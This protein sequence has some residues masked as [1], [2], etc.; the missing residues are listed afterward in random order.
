MPLYKF[1]N[2]NKKVGADRHRF[3]IDPVV[4]FDPT[5]SFRVDMSSLS[6]KQGRYGLRTLTTKS[7]SA[8]EHRRRGI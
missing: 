7:E 6:Q 3:G 8:I 2:R 4:T 1:A 5:Q